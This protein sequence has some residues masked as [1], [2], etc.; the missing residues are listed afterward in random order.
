MKTIYLT[1]EAFLS[2][3]SYFRTD[4]KGGFWMTKMLP[5]GTVLDKIVCVEEV[6]HA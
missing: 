4:T 5:D 6:R 2:I 1:R 3:D